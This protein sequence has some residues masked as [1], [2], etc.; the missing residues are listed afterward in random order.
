VEVA[1]IERR[2]ARRRFGIIPLD[3]RLPGRDLGPLK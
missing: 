1:A 3:C 2:E